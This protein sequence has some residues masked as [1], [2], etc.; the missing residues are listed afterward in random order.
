MRG[1]QSCASSSW[2]CK[3]ALPSK[4]GGIGSAVQQQVLAREVG[5]VGAADEGAELSELG[6]CAEALGGNRG[7]GMRDHFRFRLAGFLGG[8]GKAAAQALGVE[9]SGQQIV[10]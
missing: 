9:A 5:G 4:S 8:V 1:R 2:V 7:D 3:R 10:E 6:G